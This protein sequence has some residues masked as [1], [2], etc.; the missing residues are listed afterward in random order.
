MTTYVFAPTPTAPYQFQPTLDGA[1]YTANV[2]WNVFGQRWYLNVYQLDGTLVCAVAL[3]GSPDDYDINL[4]GGYFT[5]STLVFRQSS[6][7]FE[8]NP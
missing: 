4:V 8:V 2:T 6:Q 5:T 3:V 1:Q 7:N